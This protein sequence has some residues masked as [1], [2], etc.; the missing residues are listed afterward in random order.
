[1]KKIKLLVL[2]ALILLCFTGCG[3]SKTLEC[4]KSED[5]EGM[6]T[7]MTYTMKFKSDKVNYLKMGMDFE[8][9]TEE[10]KEY[11]SYS[12]GMV[13][14][15]FSEYE[16]KDGLKIDSKNDE[17]NYKYTFSME[18]DLDKL[19][20]EDLEELELDDVADSSSTYDEVKKD[21]EADGFTCK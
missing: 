11:W 19:T 13:D 12:I 6:K 18:L 1:M 8:A 21:A 14:S 17:D 7:T 2:G 5:A 3:S 9:T 4:S 16:E 15:M 20:D 10:V